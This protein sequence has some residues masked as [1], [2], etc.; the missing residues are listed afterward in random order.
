MKT[1]F[2][3]LSVFLLLLIVHPNVNAQQQPPFFDEIQHF[4]K[5]DSD[6]FPPKNAILFVGSSSLRKWQDMQDYFP[7]VKVINRGFGG[8]ELTDAIRYAKDIII[9]YHPRQIIIYS[10]ENDLAYS[11]TVTP[12]IVLERFK[13]LLTI[14]RTAMPMVPVIFISIKPSPSREKLMPEMVEANN[15]I[16]KFLQQKKKTVY[17]DVYYKMLDKDGKPMP[18]I[19]LE[20]NLHMNA[21]GYHIWQKA[22]QPFIL[23]EKK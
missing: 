21:A 10:G 8:S 23:K 13:K 9:P 4:K 1:M 2:K 17:V 6:H 22:L 5:L 16:K 3:N 15:L 11:D 20:D 12:A 14:I 7:D 18:N 19:F